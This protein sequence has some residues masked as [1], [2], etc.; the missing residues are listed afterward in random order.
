VKEACGTENYET[1]K[2]A[3]AVLNK[4]QTTYRDE[5]FRNAGK[6]HFRGADTAEF[7]QQL[8]SCV[9]G[10]VPDSAQLNTLPIYKLEER[11]EVVQPTS[12]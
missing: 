9:T 11:A 6:K 2:Q 4:A 12:S 10:E 3:V 5:L 1:K 8:G 7:N